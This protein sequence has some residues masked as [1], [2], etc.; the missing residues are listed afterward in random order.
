[1]ADTAPEGSGL[2]KWII[3]GLV[4]ATGA[5]SLALAGTSSLRAPAKEANAFLVANQEKPG[6]K[7]TDSGLQVEMLA[8]GEGPRPPPPTRSSST[9]KAAWQTARCSIRATSAASP[10]CSASPT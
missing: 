7:T 2:G 9:M 6:V 1:M 8:A 5:V 10:P 4:L 3:A